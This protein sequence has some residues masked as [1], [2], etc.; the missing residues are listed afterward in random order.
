V[1]DLTLAELRAHYGYA[2]VG[3][4]QTVPARLPVLEEVI[5]WART[6]PRLKAVVLD[7]KVPPARKELIMVVAEALRRELERKP[8]EV[9]FVCLTL[10]RTHK[11]MRAEAKKKQGKNF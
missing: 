8:V 4:D 3:Q 7:C 5:R 1:C 2:I 6:K 9:P 10:I 11:G